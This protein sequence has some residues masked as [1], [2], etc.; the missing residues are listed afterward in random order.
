MSAF[1]MPA[2][3]FLGG[4]LVGAASF[5]I[6][7]RMLEG[8]PEEQMRRQ[9]KV[10]RELE[11]EDMAGRAAGLD[12]LVGGQQAMSLSDMMAEADLLRDVT[13]S[14]YKLKKAREERPR[15]LDELNDILEGQTARV[16]ALQSE[17]VLSPLEIIQMMEGFGG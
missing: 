4:S 6:V 5:P 14:A 9:Y 7:S 13:E 2:L 11:A 1:V 3:K 10:Q 12:G 17:R 8:S 15:Y 16:A